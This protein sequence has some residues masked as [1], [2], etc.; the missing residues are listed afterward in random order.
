MSSS[1]AS[2]SV[3]VHV[4]YSDPMV[5]TVFERFRL[6]DAGPAFEAFLKRQ[7]ACFKFCCPEVVAEKLH[8]P[9]AAK[10]VIP[11]FPLQMHSKAKPQQ[12]GLGGG[13]TAAAHQG[14][15]QQQHFGPG[16]AGYVA[17]PRGRDVL[18]EY[19]FAPCGR[20]VDIYLE[21]L[22]PNGPL[23][24]VE[25]TVEEVRL[26]M[27]DA[28]Q[29]E[30]L[31]FGEP[32]T[33][34]SP[35]ARYYNAWLLAKFA[36]LYAP[37]LGNP[38]AHLPVDDQVPLPGGAVKRYR[39]LVCEAVSG[40][41]TAR[42]IV[43]D[44]LQNNR[45]FFP[46][47]L[48]AGLPGM[49]K[50]FACTRAARAL[51]VVL[52][53]HGHAGASHLFHC[54]EVQVGRLLGGPYKGDRAAQFSAL[55]SRPLGITGAALMLINEVDLAIVGSS[56][57]TTNAEAFSKW[58]TEFDHPVMPTNMHLLCTTN[59]HLSIPGN[60]KSRFSGRIMFQR[61]MRHSEYRD[62]FTRS[63]HEV[64][65]M[66]CASLNATPPNC[67]DRAAD[68]AL[69][70]SR[71]SLEAGLESTLEKVEELHR[72]LGNT[73]LTS[74][75]V[76]RTSCDLVKIA[77]RVS[78]AARNLAAFLRTAICLQRK[79]AVAFI[80]G[81]LLVLTKEIAGVPYVLVDL[82]LHP[83]SAAD[84]QLWCAEPNNPF[85]LRESTGF[86]S[87]P[88]HL[89]SKE[90]FY[91]ALHEVA[92]CSVLDATC[93]YSLQ[94]AFC[95]NVVGV[96]VAAGLSQDD[97]FGKAFTLLRTFCVE[98]APCVLVVPASHLRIS[99]GSGE[100]QNPHAASA[101]TGCEGAPLFSRCDKLAKE[102]SIVVIMCST[103]DEV[104]Y[105]Q[106]AAA[107]VDSKA[108]RTLLNITAETEYTCA[109]CGKARITDATECNCLHRPLPGAL[110]VM[111]AVRRRAKRWTRKFQKYPQFLGAETSEQVKIRNVEAA[112][113]GC[114]FITQPQG[115]TTRAFADTT[116]PLAAVVTLNPSERSFFAGFFSSSTDLVKS[117]TE[118]IKER[119]VNTD[120]S[121]EEEVDEEVD[122][123]IPLREALEGMDTG[124]VS[125]V[126]QC[127]SAC[128]T[129]LLALAGPGQLCCAT[130][131]MRPSLTAYSVVPAADRCPACRTAMVVSFALCASCG[132]LIPH[133]TPP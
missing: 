2:I 70:L 51:G 44:L 78:A 133:A 23:N 100:A 116:C 128:Q 8:N 108:M 7:H 113:G 94:E 24:P 97:L 54:F 33:D 120:V 107:F 3:R 129:N 6:Q 80:T 50:T 43:K 83:V 124:V 32:A 22:N 56:G 110:E 66:V 63:D 95:G 101:L 42:A 47:H 20:L 58:L 91:W 67:C 104:C 31:R 69:G 68:L 89:G 11:M 45:S 105:L 118:L 12:G 125:A 1:G 90:E 55:F 59:N 99:K 75:Q 114:V 86:S 4:R 81:R 15:Y 30:P 17:F 130:R 64:S 115:P 13:G 65:P 119:H 10:P 132:A 36:H 48:I 106:Q 76:Q 77:P 34:A 39:D 72:E 5:V 35:A 9:T 41:P 112:C 60:I 27:H 21:V 16:G 79:S 71:R 25:V 82:E 84:L 49:G 88:F 46:G 117:R 18:G 19:D 102:L 87:F 14:Q 85:V 126:V 29:H 28:S 96:D 109:V 122:A 93:V 74:S 38:L 62:F 57:D 37:Q 111:V 61:G 127:E 131:H 92:R 26:V 121:Y 123:V 73:F 98:C 103:C 52:P 40:I 53:T